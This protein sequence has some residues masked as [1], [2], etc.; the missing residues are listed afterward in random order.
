MTKMN[1]EVE[2]KKYMYGGGIEYT[3]MFDCYNWACEIIGATKLKGEPMLVQVPGRRLKNIVYTKR[4]Y[5]RRQQ[6]QVLHYKGK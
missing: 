6:S 1:D 5:L 2:E 3:N 4:R